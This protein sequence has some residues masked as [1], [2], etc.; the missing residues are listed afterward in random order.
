MRRWPD[1][2]PT[3]SFPGFG[4]T[5]YDAVLRTDFDVGA[6]RVRRTTLARADKI[7]CAWIFS[8]AEMAAFRA[9]FDDLPVS[10][11][12]DS[13]D[14]RGWDASAATLTIAPLTGPDGCLA[15]RIT[16]TSAVASHAASKAF[17][18]LARDSVGV[19][20]WLSIA[21]TSTGF[22]RI[23][24]T[25]RAGLSIEVT[26]DLASGAVTDA[27]A[28]VNAVSARD[29]GYW[30]LRLDLSTGIGAADPRLA[31]IVMASAATE[32]FGGAGRSID[33]CEVMVRARTGFDLFVRS[34]ADG[35]ALGAAGGSAWAEMPIATGG[36]F[37]F[38]ETRFVGP[39]SA[40]GGAGLE[41]SVTA[42]VESR[43][44]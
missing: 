43:N 35:R 41:W 8:D 22:A 38:V 44:A 30:R 9:W 34:G 25:D 32:E 27:A 19:V 42:T 14:L 24:W 3:P 1:V 21:S 39:W 10:V 18:A 20:I 13:D 5:P 26:L 7:S 33:V 36:G 37:S 31:L 28:V 6:A 4:L 12:G 11:A 2:L 23:R 40:Q 16:Q 29:A 15:T 17:P